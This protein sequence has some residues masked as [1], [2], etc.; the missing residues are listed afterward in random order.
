[1]AI[2]YRLKNWL[3]SLS[4]KPWK[5]LLRTPDRLTLIAARVALRI[6]P[7]IGIDRDVLY[8]PTGV[9]ASTAEWVSGGGRTVGADFRSVDA[10]YTANHL[11]PK[12]VH[13]QVRQQL[14]GDEV[15]PCPATFVARIPGGRVLGEGLVITP[16]DQLLDDIS[17]NF[18]EP[19]EAKL[20][21]VRREWALRPLTDVKGTVAVLSTAGAMLYYHWLFQL[22]PRFEL[23]KRS[24]IGINSIDYFLVNSAKAPF[25]RESLEALGIDQR[26]IIESSKV[27]YLRASTLVV[28]SVP[29]WGGCYAPWMREFLRNTFLPR[30][31]NEMGPATRRLYISRGSA[32]YRRVLNETDVVRLLDEFGFEEAKFESLSVR[33]QAATIAS[34]EVIVAPHGGGLSNLIFCRPATKV[35]EI[36][37]PEL[38][39]GYFWKISALLGLDYYYL[40]GKGSP[41]SS[42]ADYPQSWDAHVDIEVDLDRLRETL[43]LANIHPIK[44]GRAPSRRVRSR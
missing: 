27:P 18:G 29:L 26:K 3:K 4:R 43:A 32:G 1:V 30:S 40:L 31:D 39:A 6:V 25:Q 7:R 14:L 10:G 36:Y 20:E 17:I 37:S 24:G 35:I 22:L 19:L 33:Q 21:Y 15:Y 34:C 8:P 28:P 5:A 2:A 38:V 23:I 16:D 12:T 13:Q 42:D 41:S 9:C 11:L 44:D